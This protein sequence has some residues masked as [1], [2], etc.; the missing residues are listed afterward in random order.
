M[1]PTITFFKSIT[2]KCN[3]IPM[4]FVNDEYI[5]TPPPLKLILCFALKSSLK[6]SFFVISLKN[7]NWFWGRLGACKK[8]EIYRY[9]KAFQKCVNISLTGYFSLSGLLLFCTLPRWTTFFIA[10]SFAIFI[11]CCAVADI[12]LIIYKI[13]DGGAK[14]LK[15][16]RIT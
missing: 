3:D 6:S 2:R 15:N 10:F 1:I 13:W 4:Y 12:V 8:I 9:R 11:R 14:I 7:Y 5:A 16:H